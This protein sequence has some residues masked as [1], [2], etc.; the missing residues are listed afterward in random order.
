MKKKIKVRYIVRTT[1]SIVLIFSILLGL[2]RLVAPKY[3]EGVIEGGF[4]EEYYQETLPHDVLM[5]GDCEVYES[6]SPID[7]WREYGITSYIRGSAQQLIWQSYYLLE[8]A[9]Q[10]EK[11]KAV[12]FNVQALMHSK[13]QK[14]EY[15]RMTIDGMKWSKIKMKAIYASMLPEEHLVDYLFPIFRYHSRITELTKD[16]FTYYNRHKKVSNNGYYMR[17]DEAPYVE[18]IW[19]EDIPDT[20]QF[21]ELP[22]SYLD[23]MKELCEKNGIQL[24]LVKAPSVSPVW[25]PEYEEQVEK[26]AQ[27]NNLVYFNYLEL[28][29]DVGIDYFTDTY[30]MGLHMNLSGAKKLTSHLGQYLADEC[31]LD[32]HKSEAEYKEVW[33]EK[34]K[35]YDKMKAAQEK[36]VQEYGYVVSY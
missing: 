25:Y 12:I 23:K 2:Q 18:G 4:T 26:Y 9:L 16:D 5:V 6:F 22:M 17:I 10:Y 30:D 28:A 1:I 21:G 20:Y 19:E 32:G 14:E 24:I 31:N 13:P 3:T 34:E 8:D 11:P 36:E 33:K 27:K 7:L 15:N 29:D 35:F